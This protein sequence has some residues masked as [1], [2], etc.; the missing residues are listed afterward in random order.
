MAAHAQSADGAVPFSILHPVISRGLPDEV[1]LAKL[2]PLLGFS[3]VLAEN[4]FRKTPG[5]PAWGFPFS[6]PEFLSEHPLK[7]SKI[8]ARTGANVCAAR[9]VQGKKI[10][11]L[12]DPN[13][14]PRAPL[15]ALPKNQVQTGDLL[16]GPLSFPVSA[17]HR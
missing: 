5:W 8:L 3:C 12:A 17:D 7:W 1:A 15:P 13:L 14:R 10:I 4:N 9:S 6:D 11:A 16:N 2:E